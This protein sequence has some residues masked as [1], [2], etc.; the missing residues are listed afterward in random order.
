MMKKCDSITIPN[1]LCKLTVEMTKGTWMFI[2]KW[3]IGSDL[4]TRVGKNI[5]LKILIAKLSD[6][7]EGNYSEL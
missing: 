5:K 1:T 3:P 2:E 4:Q 7:T 6:R